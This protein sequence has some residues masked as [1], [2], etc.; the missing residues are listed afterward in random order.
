[1]AFLDF[2]TGIS[3]WYWVAFALALG[4]LEMAT[5]TF[6]LIW[7][8]MAAAT[9]ALVLLIAP[10]MSPNLQVACFSILSI[11]FTLAGR[12]L[13]RHHLNGSDQANPL[14]NNRAQRLIGKTAVVLEYD[15]GFGAVEIEGMR[16]QANWAKDTSSNTGDKTRILGAEGMVLN[17]EPLID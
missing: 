9:M 3:P 7:P 17:V 6:F 15:H 10:D 8:A 16:W 4:A 12:Y 1:M 13:F 5:F 14:L 2:L 11:V